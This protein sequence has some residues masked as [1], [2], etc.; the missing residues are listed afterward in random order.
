ML[1]LMSCHF[2]GPQGGL[3]TPIHFPRWGKKESRCLYALETRSATNSWL[4]KMWSLRVVVVCQQSRS[5]EWRG[6]TRSD[7]S[8]E[9]QFRRAKASFLW[10]DRR[11]LARV[12]ARMSEAGYHCDHTQT[13]GTIRSSPLRY[14]LSLD[15]QPFAQHTWAAFSKAL[16]NW[17]STC[18][19]PN[20]RWC[21]YQR[22]YSGAAESI[23][24]RITYT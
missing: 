8:S 20:G 19:E 3:N 24:L 6:R 22:M 17:A 11:V 13:H 10:H 14:R 2:L 7:N 18:I 23:L 1:R 15:I 4:V 9:R 16:S 12:R 5:R 21:E